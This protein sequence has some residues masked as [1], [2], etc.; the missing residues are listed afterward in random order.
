MTQFWIIIGL[1]FSVIGGVFAW[2]IV[3]ERQIARMVTTDKAHE[4]R[5][6]IL[7]DDKKE[8]YIRHLNEINI[9]SRELHENNKSIFS[10]LDDITKI[11]TNIRIRCAAHFKE[12]VND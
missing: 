9:T 1:L 10:K 2:A 4:E 7:E 6:A 11:T 3:I 8:D 12:E 5:I